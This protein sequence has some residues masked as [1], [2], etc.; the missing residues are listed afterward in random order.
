MKPK[1]LF[2]IDAYALIFRGYYAFIKNPRI[3]SKGLD[4]SA[5]LGFMNALLD[6][7]RREK[8][9]HL[10]VAFDKGGSQ[11]RNEMYTEYKSNRQETP[12]AIRT[13]VPYIHDI[14]KAMRIPIIE[15]EGYEADDL[16][17]TLAGQAAAKEYEVYMVTPDKDFAQLVSDKVFLYKP[18]RMGNG[19]EIWGVPEVQ[20]KFEVERPEQ[21]IDFLGMMGDSVDNIPGLPG[22][23][24]KTA[25]KFIKAY[26][27][28]EN[29]LA[30]THEL[31]GKLREKIEAHKELGLLSKELATIITD[32]PVEFNEEDFRMSKP[33]M[34][35]VKEIF[36]ELEFR[37]A[38]E[39]FARL[40][41][42]EKPQETPPA[43]QKS[44]SPAPKQEGQQ[45]DLF[46]QADA[47]TEE[48]SSS[49]AAKDRHYQYIH[50]EAGYRLLAQHLM[51]QKSVA[52]AMFISG[53]NVFTADLSGISFSYAP[54]KAYYVPIPAGKEQ[55]GEV[56]AFFKDFFESEDIGKN[57]HNMKPGVKMLRR[58]GIEIK[59]QL[60]DTALAHY[61]LQPEARHNLYRLS[62]QYL[63]EQIT[64][65]EKLLGKGV[66]QKTYR[67][68]PLEEMTEFACTQVDITGRLRE[69]LTAKLEA[70]K[71]H[72]LFYEVESPLVE[73]LADMELEGIRID[74]DF[75]AGLTRELD[76][77]MKVLE[78]K[79]FERVGKKFNLASPKQ[80]G[81]ILF[82][83]MK[84][85]ENPKKTK[86]GQYATGEEILVKLSKKHPVIADILEWRA[87]VKLKNTYTEALPKEIQAETGRLHTTFSQTVTATGRLSSLN[88]NIQNIPVRTPR[89]REV[90]R[91]FV[92]RDEN[93][94]LMAADYSQIE[95]RIIAELSGDRVMKE[96]FIHGEDIH[97]ATAAKVFGVPLEEVTPL[98]RRHAKT[99][100][101]GII[102]GVS[103][104]GLSNQTELSRS[105][106]K[107][108]IET[109]FETYPDLKRYIDRQ[110]ERAEEYGY[111]ETLLGRRRYLPNI[112][113]HNHVVRAFDRRNAVNAPV[114]GTAAD[115]IKI[116]MIRVFEH[117]N[118]GGFR[119]KMLLQ[120]H[121]EL[122][123][124]IHRD[125]LEVLSSDIRDIMENAFP[126]SIPLKV[127][128]GVGE[129]WLEA[130]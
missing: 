47:L 75:L 107:Q 38:W 105:E 119:S 19:V 45:L 87:L 82:G 127:D 12:E 102:Y 28:M 43:S 67:D 33:D 13:A 65:E 130:H 71:M 98:Q 116:A 93:Y 103:A 74:A 23:G 78:E 37:R 16:I 51:Q 39:T 3:N 112:N 109:Y 101:F 55:T 104:F 32:A 25:K 61:L 79:I 111:V 36:D 123:F 91:A 31:K 88:P 44:P 50:T 86:T 66:K 60:F 10:A 128:V 56:L 95:L 30:H 118:K 26:G 8:P 83:E 81:E 18:A 120:I 35:R 29:L 1:K 54:H 17:G 106:A 40:F 124:D 90:R 49:N 113:S 9:D 126:L 57:G 85:V 64:D 5:I 100:N 96:S 77:D 80:L 108:L 72:K 4:T 48:A 68:I 117:L 21:V 59:G 53:Q 70:N 22:V 46:A 99:V 41:Q 58:S 121:D 122:I 84:L 73:V 6:V 97:R 20:R 76:K 92:A 7:I 62:E 129:N 110:V 115:I 114:Q 15:V 11:V 34:K 24:E 52:V 63:D 125:E 27:S 89:G 2:L 69:L 42:E 14:L 94:V